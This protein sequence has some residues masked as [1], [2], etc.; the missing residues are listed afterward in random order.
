MILVLGGIFVLRL[1]QLQLFGD[2]YAI[3][4]KN[5]AI[6]ELEIYPT[7][8]L[9]YDRDS[10]LIVYNEAIYDLMV[11]PKLAKDID[12][13][14]FCELLKISKDEYISRWQKMKQTQGYSYY[15]PAVFM[16]Q[17][18]MTDYAKF[19]EF[20][21]AFPGFYGQ[22]RTVRQYPHK[23]G[24]LLL[25]DIGE[26]SEK[27]IKD[28]KDYY[29]PGDYVGKNGLEKYYETELGGK[30]GVRAIYVDVLGRE[31]G[32]FAGGQYDKAA[33]AGDILYSTINI[34]LQA[35]GEK[36]MQN[37]KGSIVAIEPS[38]G[39]ILC[40]VSSPTYDP[41]G[42][43]GA[44]RGYNYNL[45]LKDSMKPLYNR[46]T[47]A[48]YPPGST[49]KP[50]VGLIALQE[51]VQG[52]VHTI[53]CN[54]YYRLGGLTLKCSH[55][56]PW[57]TNIQ[58]AIAQSC[59]P[60]FWQTFR[61]AIENPAYKTIQDSYGVWSDF[62]K[63]F[64]L[65]MKMQVDLPSESK[66]NIPSVKYYNKIYGETGWR[67]AT[68]ISLGIGQG[69]ILVTPLQLCNLYATIANK[70]YYFDPH[71]ARTIVDVTTGK[72]IKHQPVKHETG[73]AREYFDATIE[74]L[75]QVVMNGTASSSKIE[76]ITMC[77]KTGTV[78]NPHG[79]D[80]SI[81]AGF[82]PMENPKIA[83]AVVVENAGFGARYAGPIASLMVEKYINDTIAT[84][85]LP[86]EKRMTDANLMGKYYKS[87]V[88]LDSATAAIKP[89]VPQP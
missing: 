47:L 75:Y 79:D 69:E 84:K 17:I 62:C 20:L 23:A 5:N 55:H 21:Y 50:L 12:T 57:A 31:Q 67:S 33:Q 74:G 54:G 37:K 60:Y 72:N 13:A 25:G 14:K 53:P 38:T 88:V 40:M 36:L 29:K 1:G 76:G 82:A 48:T 3:M 64:G 66:G 89:V 4:A 49:F 45:L 2:K 22:V 86:M 10:E 27:Q 87:P 61:N 24:A 59:N 52:I 9:I 28:S 42:L 32:S 56:H 83:F 77:G 26:V 16:K 68:I 58:Y 73:V 18:S 7:R 11:M 15:K 70:G 39:E 8:G 46:A 41:N 51:G 30:K 63:K 80:H 44:Q 81:F 65:G 85:R 78:Q 19:Q 34:E 6:R 35:F 43:T 71:L